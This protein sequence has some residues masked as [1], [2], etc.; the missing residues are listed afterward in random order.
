[1]QY[2]SHRDTILAYDRQLRALAEKTADAVITNHVMD[3]DLRCVTYSNGVK[4]YVNYGHT[5][6]KTPDGLTVDAMSFL[7]AEGGEKP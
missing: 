7:I 2:A 6:A 1:M 4:V 3:G 5:P